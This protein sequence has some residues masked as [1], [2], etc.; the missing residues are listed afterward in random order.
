MFDAVTQV[1]P[2]VN[3]PVHDFAPG[4]AERAALEETLKQLA[5]E[6]VDLTMAVGGEQRAGGGEPIDVVQPHRKDAVLGTMHNATP[7]DAADAVEAAR[8]AAPAWRRM[9]Y[10]D[11]AAAAP[12]R[13][14]VVRPGVSDAPAHRRGQQVAPTPFAWRP[15]RRTVLTG[16]RCPEQDRADAPAP[17][18]S[19]PR[20]RAGRTAG[21]RAVR[22]C[23][24]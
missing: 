18:V 12:R 15:S 16:S 1:P 7:A 4:S 10:D 24:G 2:P 5:A 20:G 13:A 14:G 22:P 8:A 23:D 6:R 11:R 17:M 21:W 9:S 3:E 19:A